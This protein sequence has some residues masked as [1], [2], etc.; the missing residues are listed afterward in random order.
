MAALWKRLEARARGFVLRNRGFSSASIA[1]NSVI[2]ERENGQMALETVWLRDHCRAG[3]RYSWETHQRETTLDIEHLNV[4]AHRVQVESDQLVVDWEDGEKSC[5]S[6]DWLKKNYSRG[7]K[8]VKALLWGRPEQEQLLANTKIEWENFMASDEAVASLLTSIIRYGVGQVVGAPASREGTRAVAE[9][10][11][12]VMKDSPYEEVWEFGSSRPTDEEST[13]SSYSSQAL[14]SHTDGTY[15]TESPG[16]QA[17]HITHRASSGGRTILCDGWKVASALKSTHPELYFLLSSVPI[18]SEYIHRGGKRDTHYSTTDTILKH[19]PL[20]KELVQI[21][22]NT[23]DRSPMDSVASELLSQFYTAL[24]ALET[25]LGNPQ[26]QVNIDLDPGT[27]L[28]LDNWRVTH[29]RTAYTGH[30]TLSG[31]YISRSDWR[32]RARCLGLL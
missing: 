6:L 11:A 8:K 9:R 12:R 1:G 2:V 7:D 22:Y 3:G 16:L 19:C 17:F 4:P 14:F 15:M 24:A 25:E 20:T 21:R 31:C 30:R 10:T 32:S 13:D 27:V 26:N 28:L 18:P 23:Y 5:Y 29:S